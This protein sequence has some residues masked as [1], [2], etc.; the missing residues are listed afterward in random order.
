MNINS[1]QGSIVAIVTP[2]N[3]DDS[4]DFESYEKLLDF[5]LENSTDGIV[6]CGTT[7]EAATLNSEEYAS[8]IKFTTEKINGRIPIIVG[9]GSNSTEKAMQ[10][11]LTAQE[12][13]A[14]AVLIVN[15]YYNKPNRKGIIQYYESI[16]NSIDIPIIIYNVPSRTGANISADLTLELARRIPK[17]IGIKEASGN[18]EQVMEI[19]QK[20]PEGLK[21]YSG[22]DNLAYSI[23][24]LGGDGC[25]SVVANQTPY[26]FRTML[27]LVRDGRFDEARQIHYKLLKLMKLNFIESNPIPVKTSLSKMKLIRNYYRSPL[28][29]MENMENEQVLTNELQKLGL[30]NINEQVE[31][32]ATYN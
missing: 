4:I 28:C 20:K 10:H 2:F 27:Q 5:H 15:P 9:A 13:G 17:I 6:V 18:L 21:V 3:S 23:V 25:I 16:A 8:L 19:L 14:D 1:P 22:E 32:L 26:E 31:V 7:G 30:L 29:T 11:S 24:A 12:N